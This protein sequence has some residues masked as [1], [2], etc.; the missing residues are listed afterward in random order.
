MRGSSA[1]LTELF[2]PHVYIQPVIDTVYNESSSGLWA[3]C[4]LV[5]GRLPRTHDV[6][7]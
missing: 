4:R 5:E 2:A 6:H 3:E 1:C 7:S